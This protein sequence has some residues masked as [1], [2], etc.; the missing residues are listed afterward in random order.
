MGDIS[1]INIKFS[2]DKFTKEFSSLSKSISEA[3]IDSVVKQADYKKYRKLIN[4]HNA[5]FIEIPERS[6]SPLHRAVRDHN[7]DIDA[8]K[9][10]INAVL[11][12][13][14]DINH[15]DKEGNTPLVFLLSEATKSEKKYSKSYLISVMKFLIERG[16]YLD[17]HN[18]SEWD[19][20]SDLINR[21]KNNKVITQ[22]EV[23]DIYRAQQ[24]LKEKVK[25]E[26]SAHVQDIKEV[27]IYGSCAKIQ[28]KDN[29]NEFKISE[30]LQSDFCKNNG[31]SGFST[32][33]DN[34]KSGMH[35]VVSNGIR[36]Y[37]VTD[38]AYEMTL[39]WPANGVNHTIKIHINADGTVK[40]DQDY[41]SK[42]QAGEI[43]VN[44]N[45]D[46]KLGGLFLAEALA[47]G[48]WKENEVQNDM[49]ETIRSGINV[50][51]EIVSKSGATHTPEI[52]SQPVTTSTPLP[53]AQLPNFNMSPI[54]YNDDT[55]ESHDDSSLLS[56]VFYETPLS[57]EGNA[58]FERVFSEQNGTPE[59]QSSYSVLE[60]QQ[61]PVVQRQSESQ[62]QQV[63]TQ[64]YVGRHEDP[65][66]IEDVTITGTK[67]FS[68]DNRSQVHSKTPPPTP[69]R[70]S[71]L[72]PQN[73]PM[74]RPSG[75]S[76]GSTNT[77][78]NFFN[79]YNSYPKLTTFFPAA[80]NAPTGSQQQSEGK[81]KS[82][83]KGNDHL[84]NIPWPERRDSGYSSPT[85]D[86]FEHQ[87]NSQEAQEKRNHRQAMREEN[88]RDQVYNLQLIFA[89]QRI[90]P[91]SIGHIMNGQ[92]KKNIGQSDQF[93][94]EEFLKEIRDRFQQDNKGGLKKV[95][96]KESY[97]SPQTK[98]RLI[99]AGLLKQTKPGVKAVEE[100]AALNIK[101]SDE[102][103]QE[104]D[105]TYDFP[106]YDDSEFE[107]ALEVLNKELNASEENKVG[108]TTTANVEG[109]SSPNFDTELLNV[110]KNYFNI[111]SLPDKT[112]QIDSE[113][114][115][116]N[117]AQSNP[118]DQVMS[119][120]KE[121]L[122]MP[123]KGLNPTPQVSKKNISLVNAHN[124]FSDCIKDKNNLHKLLENDNAR[125]KI[126][127]L[128]GKRKDDLEKPTNGYDRN[129][130]AS[131]NQGVV[132][133][134][135]TQ[136][137]WVERTALYKI[138]PNSLSKNR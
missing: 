29:K 8:V 121:A 66:V 115:K 95:D 125:L 71:P 123:N 31:I 68:S 134:K 12:S 44:A 20:G 124:P 21:L 122:K 14:V 40:V 97:I 69:L 16:A 104:W 93:E 52:E 107:E 42:Y 72:T 3:E 90:T 17:K 108:P 79:S 46:V 11:Q 26:L 130:I 138:N 85:N 49:S 110:N 60:N 43:D 132:S 22:K 59:S 61:Q 37:V 67:E 7:D 116:S 114:V 98:Q 55:L 88:S 35:G 77:L 51:R 28:L 10:T 41:L 106:L 81:Q 38:G 101:H 23:D 111:S 109:S 135:K 136:K 74:S 113:T 126:G 94:L 70:V 5:T 119:E 33:H 73:N 92:S 120:L 13:G 2:N 105:S 47:K 100:R 63:N 82:E 137:N 4:D 103:Q 78:R 76:D 87:I 133:S 6:F 62:Q 24:D 91:K 131:G 75:N 45:K 34:G 89:D 57:P 54:V 64:P 53:D 99:E 39:N 118:A 58:F 117:N 112:K 9:E 84:F 50:T 102:A 128:E 36:H 96:L 65:P 56:P 27:S 86:E 48:R 25:K 19:S 32:L 129:R 80:T 30:F 127:V 18:E 83:D 1:N 15:L